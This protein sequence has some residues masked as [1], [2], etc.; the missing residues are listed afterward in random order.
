MLRQAEAEKPRQSYSDVSQAFGCLA[1]TGRRA[2]KDV[3]AAYA[4][5]AALLLPL[6]LPLLL[7]CDAASASTPAPAPMVLMVVLTLLALPTLPDAVTCAVCAA[8]A[9]TM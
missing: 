2:A 7:C 5:A 1:T 3:A 4:F 9:P 8:Q 6:P